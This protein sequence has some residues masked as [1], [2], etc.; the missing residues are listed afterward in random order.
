[1]DLPFLH[2]MSGETTISELTECLID[3]HAIPHRVPH[4]ILTKELSSH[5]E[6]CD[7]RPTVMESSSLTVSPTNL[8]H[9]A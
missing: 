5:Q 9:L 4:G 3:H 7:S 2:V 8:R 1:M 6:K